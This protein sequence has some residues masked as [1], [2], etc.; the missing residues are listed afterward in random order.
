MAASVQMSSLGKYRV[1][2]KSFWTYNSVSYINKITF[3]WAYLEFWPVLS[4]VKTGWFLS[5]HLGISTR[6]VSISFFFF[7]KKKNKLLHLFVFRLM[8]NTFRFFLLLCFHI[9]MA[10]RKVFFTLHVKRSR[11]TKSKQNSYIWL[12]HASWKFLFQFHA[13]RVQGT[14]HNAPLMQINITCDHRKWGANHCG[15][16]FT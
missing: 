16:V 3:L 10:S 6:K 14:L 5:N 8:Q 15:L 9:F 7:Y 13:F 1:V 12:F 2:E 11:E 4:R